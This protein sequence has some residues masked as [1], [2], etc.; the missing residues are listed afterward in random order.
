V[1]EW[2]PPELG[3][4]GEGWVVL[5]SLLF[6]AI[7]ASGFSGVDWPSSVSSFFA[8]L[9]IVVVVLG[10]VLFALGV[11]ALGRSFTAFPRPK[12]R[13]EFRQGGI[14]RSVRHPVYGGVLMFALGWSLAGS[15]LAL[16]PTALLA[17]L[18]DLK[19]RREEAWLVERYPAYEGYRR[20]TPHRLIPF[21]Y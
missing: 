9:G 16:F 12:E 4:R 11:F 2:R 20:G 18:F 13:S 7:V 3:P 8:V 10:A 1:S 15:P 14:Y 6:V 17:V 19:S 5:Q 21:V